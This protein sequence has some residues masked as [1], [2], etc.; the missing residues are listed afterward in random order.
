MEF[1]LAVSLV[2]ATGQVAAARAKISKGAEKRW[3][4]VKVQ[5]KKAAA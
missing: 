4:K 2:L 1:W 3:A 5:R